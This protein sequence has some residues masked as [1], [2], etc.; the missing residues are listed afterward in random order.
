MNKTTLITLAAVIIIAIGYFYVTGE[1]S[2]QDAA[3]V[4]ATNTA[5]AA[6]GSRVLAILNQIQQIKI[7]NT[8]FE[9]AA[10]RS[11]VDYSVE[12]PAQNVG[13]PNPF[14]PLPGQVAAPSQAVKK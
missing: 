3:V 8:F 12:I 2:T 4:T 9:S 10:Y 6:I 7:D 13:R 1:E 5:D 11:L 14:A